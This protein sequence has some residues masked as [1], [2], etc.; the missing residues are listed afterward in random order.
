MSLL[1]VRPLF[2]LD[3]R[4]T[5]VGSGVGGWDSELLLADRSTQ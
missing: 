1:S 5:F 2:L 4:F 3:I